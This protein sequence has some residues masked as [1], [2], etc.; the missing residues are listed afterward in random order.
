[1]K[2]LLSISM[3]DVL[4]TGDLHPCVPAVPLIYHVAPFPMPNLQRH[5]ISH[6]ELHRLHISKRDYAC[7]CQTRPFPP[8]GPPLLHCP[9]S[10]SQVSITSYVL[11]CL[12]LRFHL[13]TSRLQLMSKPALLENHDVMQLQHSQCPAG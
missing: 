6:R 9:L 8:M 7:S 11:A 4:F 5:D 13:K 10:L 12:A 3:G 1:M 2:D